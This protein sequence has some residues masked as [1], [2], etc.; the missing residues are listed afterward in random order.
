MC[1][2]GDAPLLE[3]FGDV[4]IL[5]RLLAANGLSRMFEK[6]VHFHAADILNGREREPPVLHDREEPFLLRRERAA[7]LLAHDGCLRHVVAR[8]P[9][10]KLFMLEIVQHGFEAT[11]L[12]KL[13]VQLAEVFTIADAVLANV[14]DAPASFAVPGRD[15]PVAVG[16]D[17]ELE[18]VL[19]QLR[20]FE[21][22]LLCI[23]RVGNQALEL[24]LCGLVAGPDRLVRKE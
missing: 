10:A 12:V 20:A 24:L 6:V 8:V 19:R 16:R 15:E 17:Q 11:V 7:I 22:L 5:K 2:L 21:L 18:A 9:I 13:L 14:A 3:Q 4:L 1:C 23:G